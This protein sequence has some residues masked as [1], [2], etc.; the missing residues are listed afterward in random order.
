MSGCVGACKN[1]LERAGECGSVQER[2]GVYRS[3]RECTEAC[4]N[5][6]ERAILQHHEAQLSQEA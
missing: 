5:V 3:V 1:G 4:G 6:R 2:A